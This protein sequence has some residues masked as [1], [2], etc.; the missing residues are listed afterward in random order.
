M[1]VGAGRPAV[2][3]AGPDYRRAADRGGRCLQSADVDLPAS[4]VLKLQPQPASR[5]LRQGWGALIAALLCILCL[6]PRPAAAEFRVEISG[7]G[8]TQLP[9]ALATFR[10]EA[11]SGVAVS[12]VVRA[13]LERSGMFRILP[14]DAK[15][16]ERSNVDL[17]PWR[18]AGADALVAGSVT[19]LVDGRFDVR[20]K[21]WDAV[22][23]DQLLGQSK[24]VVAADLR[25]AA[26]RVADEI[27]QKL[28]GERGV[29]A[30]RIAYV[31]RKGR[32]S[33][34][35]ITDADGEGGQVALASPEPIISPAWSPDGRQLAYVSFESQK[36]VV[37]VQDLITGKRHVVANYRGSNSAPAWSPDG[38]R[39]A[40]VLSRAGL[41]QIYT[42]SAA[43][44]AATR[45]LT[46]NGIDTE[47]VYAPD[48]GSI[49]FVSD[50]GGGPQIYRVGVGGG[51]VERITFDGEYNISPAISPD[52]KLL[53]YITRQDNAF[54]LMLMDLG[55]GS[56]QALTD[57]RDDESPSFAPNG[58][59]LV[60]S[61][62][63]QG[64]GV[65]MTTTLDGKIKTR[66]YSSGSDVR[67][68]TWG[69]YG[70]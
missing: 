41:P 7:V 13:D 23:G 63:V 34:L 3:A 37:W 12:Q 57:T 1:L 21:L 60:Y 55:S 47:P 22:K 28:T 64:S 62:Q 10:D 15:L 67:E 53:A 8:A 56:T 66:L 54:H 38:S 69:P 5:G 9:L 44:G 50:R 30:T 6:A 20:Y 18:L 49:Y 43:G 39:L 35:Y 65:L 29:N 40:V 70:R 24:V 27:Y 52:G 17:A 11:A 25:L 51:A 61:T 4:F 36:A 32:R 19:R 46:S 58:R 68:P 59:L 26:H 45:L 16:D 42:V 14:A 48:G 2:R 31:A 33:T